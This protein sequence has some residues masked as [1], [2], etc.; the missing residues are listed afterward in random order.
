VDGGLQAAGPNLFKRLEVFRGIR[1]VSRGTT[2]QQP[3]I[4]S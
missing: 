1:G 2:G 4:R 3:I